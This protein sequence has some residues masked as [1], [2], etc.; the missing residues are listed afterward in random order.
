MK[1]LETKLR[2]WRPRR[3]SGILKFRLA[4]V[5]GKFLRNATHYAG[6]LAPA[7]ACVWLTLISLNSGGDFSVHPPRQPMMAMI[8]SNQNHAAFYA[9]WN[10]QGENCPPDQIFRWTNAGASPSSIRFT[11]GDNH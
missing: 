3:P 4:I 8:F 6:W 2:S 5:P 1:S 10:E 9:D 11:S 7:A